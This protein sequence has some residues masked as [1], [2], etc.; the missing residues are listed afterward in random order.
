MSF[1]RL[2]NARLGSGKP[3]GSGRHTNFIPTLR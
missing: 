3:V 1:R 2:S